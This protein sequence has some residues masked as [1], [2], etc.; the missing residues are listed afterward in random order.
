MN[1]WLRYFYIIYLFCLAYFVLAV[2][3]WIYLEWL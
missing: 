1:R 2:L 3:L